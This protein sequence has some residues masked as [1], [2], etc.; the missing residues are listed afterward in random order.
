MS[1]TGNGPTAADLQALL[2]EMSAGAN[3][4]TRTID[5]VSNPAVRKILEQAS[6][7]AEREGMTSSSSFPPLHGAGVAG[8]GLF[9]LPTV[10]EIGT[11]MWSWWRQKKINEEEK[12]RLKQEVIEKQNRIICG[13]QKK[14]K[15]LQEKYAVIAEKLN[16]CIALIRRMDQELDNRE[17]ELDELK[18]KYAEAKEQMKRNEYTAAV[19]IVFA[20]MKQEFGV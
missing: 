2:D 17:K 16:E 6:A 10:F 8:L 19:F 9:V 14:F 1:E 12:E 11:I 3:D 15:E 20:N 4:E 13:L 7:S 5:K 18:K